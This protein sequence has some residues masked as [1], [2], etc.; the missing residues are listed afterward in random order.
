[1]L[2][3]SVYDSMRADKGCDHWFVLPSRYSIVSRS[4]RF[5]VS[6][7][8]AGV[9]A[10]VERPDL[11][12]KLFVTDEMN[13]AGVYCVKLCKDGAWQHVIL[14]GMFPINSG[15]ALAYAQPAR[16][17]LWVMLLDKAFAKL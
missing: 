13:E 17:Q 14:D 7:F 16:G 2:R 1:M 6:R 4:S 3:A 15:G 8:L 9:A 10:V 11:V 5:C 12:R